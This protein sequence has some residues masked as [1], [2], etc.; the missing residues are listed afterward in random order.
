MT[1]V[2]RP[3]W[4]RALTVAIAVICAGIVVSTAIA[5]DWADAGLLAPW[6]ALF[7]IVCWAT[8]W[9][10]CVVVSDGG[11]RLVN[12][13]R[14]IDIPW[15]AL[16]AVETKWALALVTAYGRFT[17]WSAPAPGVRGALLSR[18][19][20]EPA[21]PGTPDP[22]RPADLADT[23]SGAAAA[24]IFERWHELQAAGHLD[25]PRLERDRATVRWHLG[26]AAFALALIAVGV[27]TSL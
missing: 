15:P 18:A 9:R 22:V 1:E 16:R 21:R 12:V 14:T 24:L 17:A 4:G 26:T 8:F 5:G 3:W 2:F 11:V 23:P 19:A 7:A 20:T 25:D 6:A 13:T 27:A 10:P